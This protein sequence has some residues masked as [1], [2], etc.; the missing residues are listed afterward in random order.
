MF[1]KISLFLALTFL[2]VQSN[3]QKANI[4]SA[5]NYLKDN[6]IA[7]AKKMIDEATTSESTKN[8][9]KAWLLKAVIYQAIGTPKEVMPQLQFILNENP[10]IISLENANTL[11]SVAPN[12]LNDAIDAYKKTISLDPKYTKEELHA[13][14]IDYI[15]C[16][17]Q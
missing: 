6:D 1:K 7:N 14:I 10:Y 3:A 4:Q 11:M 13:L 17:I 5:I 8:N 12:A 9:A 2:M 15:G 16:A